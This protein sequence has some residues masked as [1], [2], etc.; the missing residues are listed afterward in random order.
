MS[1]RSY[2]DLNVWK[3]SIALTKQIYILSESFPK[4]ETYGITQQLRR[5]A[6]SVPSN[7]AEGH[8]RES[9]REYLHHISIA[10]G[11]LAEL[12]T[13]IIIS[14]EL[15]FVSSEKINTILQE[16]DELGKMLRGLQSSL[17]IKL[18]SKVRALEPSTKNLKPI[19]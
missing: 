4:H 7:I 17:K 19:T 16:A 10:F 2:R 12:E 9:L 6:A 11:S 1:I 18:S 5:S 13:Q 8:G 14:K 15:G 3:K